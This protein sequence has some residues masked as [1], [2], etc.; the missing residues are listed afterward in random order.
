MLIAIDYTFICAFQ[1]Y[2]YNVWLLQLVDISERVSV[3]A[4]FSL[5]CDLFRFHTKIRLFFPVPTYRM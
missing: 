4:F 3:H 1:I 5:Y 2:A